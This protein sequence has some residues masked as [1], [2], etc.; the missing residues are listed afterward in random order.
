MATIYPLGDRI[1]VLPLKASETFAGSK[2]V[3]PETS[4]HRDKPKEGVVLEIGRGRQLDNGML[5]PLE[6]EPGDVVQFS[7]YAGVVVFDEQVGFDVLLM[8]E[9]E[10]LGRKKRYDLPDVLPGDPRS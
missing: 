10:A 9:E 2:L 3:A 6:C 4:E 1:K 7:K 8:R 5:V